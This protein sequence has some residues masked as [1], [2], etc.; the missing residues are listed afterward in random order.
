MTTRYRRRP[1]EVD[2]LLYDGINLEQVQ[3]FLGKDFVGWRG[4]PDDM[5]LLI[6]TMEHQ[7]V[8]YAAR[9]GSWIVCGIDGEHWAV[10]DKVF[11]QTYE[12]VA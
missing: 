3:A 9:P 4:T 8:P 10:A 1:V 2:A 7:D 6:R 12:P 5:T 11:M